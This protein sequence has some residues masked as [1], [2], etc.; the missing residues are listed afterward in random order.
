MAATEFSMIRMDEN[1]IGLALMQLEPIT[2]KTH[3][4]RIQCAK[5]NIPIVGDATYGDY[6]FNKT[7]KTLTGISRLF[8]HCASTTIKFT[9]DG[10]EQKFSAE[11]PM[12]ESFKTLIDYNSRIISVSRGF[13]R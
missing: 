2:G 11:A 6:T 3:Q 7:I 13:K 1:S 8:L 10:R 4:L 5:R 9:M 12:P